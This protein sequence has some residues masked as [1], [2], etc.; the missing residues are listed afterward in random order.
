MVIRYGDRQGLEALVDIV[1]DSLR[2]SRQSAKMSRGLPKKIPRS[3]SQVAREHEMDIWQ[4]LLG[5]KL[6]I[7]V[8]SVQVEVG[9]EILM[10]LF[11]DQY[12]DNRARD[13]TVIPNSPCE[14]AW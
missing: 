3:S 11:V 6:A 8:S 5:M 2:H 10:V 14:E 1:H 13:A 4:D 7:W 9:S 12:D